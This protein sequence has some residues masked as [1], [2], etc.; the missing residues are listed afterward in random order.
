MKH[1][2][3]TKAL[4]V[5]LSF[6]MVMSACFVAFPSLADTFGLK[7]DAAIGTVTAAHRT[8]LQNALTAYSNVASNTDRAANAAVHVAEALFPAVQDLVTS[9]SSWPSAS[10]SH[11]TMPWSNW[12][13][14]E[15]QGDKTAPF[16]KE[17]RDVILGYCGNNTQKT[18]INSLMPYYGNDSSLE[19]YSS[20]NKLWNINFGDGWEVGNDNTSYSDYYQLSNQ[21]NPVGTA[22]RTEKQALYDYTLADL[23]SSSIP[24]TVRK[25]YSIEYKTGL[26]QTGAE[27]RYLTAKHYT[28]VEFYYFPSGPA[29][30]AETFSI[31]NYRDDLYTFFNR[32]TSARI[33]EDPFAVYANLTEAQAAVSANNTAWNAV[34]G[35]SRWDKNVTSDQ[36]IINYFGGQVTTIAGDTVGSTGF[37]NAVVKY[38][39][40]CV[41]AVNYYKA[42]PYAEYIADYLSGDHALDRIRL[43]NLDTSYMERNAA[44]NLWSTLTSKKNSIEDIYASTKP[45]KGYSKLG[46]V[47]GYY[48][49]DTITVLTLLE[50][51]WEYIDLKKLKETIDEKIELFTREVYRDLTTVSDEE[52]DILYSTVDGW[53]DILDSNEYSAKVKNRVF[54]EGYQ[55]VKDYLEEIEYEV[56]RRDFHSELMPIMAH[57]MPLFNSNLLSFTPAQL[58]ARINEDKAIYQGETWEPEGVDLTE[59]TYR[60]YIPLYNAYKPNTLIREDFLEL[61]DTFNEDLQAYMKSLHQALADD[62]VV[63]VTDAMNYT[64]AGTAEITLNNFSLIKTSVD[65][66]RNNYMTTY[67]VTV[68]EGDDA[69]EE[70]VYIHDWLLN[71]ASIKGQTSNDGEGHLIGN[72]YDI[73]FGNIFNVN[74]TMSNG[75]VY[76]FANAYDIIMNGDFMQ[77]YEA[78][79]ATGGLDHWNQL[80]FYRTD[81]T[82]TS[83]SAVAGANE[84]NQVKYASNTAPIINRLPYAD[85]LGRGNDTL[86]NDTYTVTKTKMNDL[87]NQLDTFLQSGDMVAILSTL[88]DS[89]MLQDVN[90]SEYVM[91]LLS[92]KLFTDE[93]MNKLTKLIFPTLT[94]KLELLWRELDGKGE[95]YASVYTL[96]GGKTIYYIADQLHIAAYPSQIKNVFSSIPQLSQVAARMNQATY[97]RGDFYRAD[98]WTSLMNED[99]DLDFVWGIDA[100]EKGANESYEAW[101]TRR[102]GAFKVAL[103][104]VLNCLKDIA[105]ALFANQTYNADDVVDVVRLKVLAIF[106]G[107]PNL[108]DFEIQGINGY[109]RVIVPLLEALGCADA[110]IIPSGQVNQRLYQQ[111]SNSTAALVNAIFDPIVHLVTDQIAT[112]PLAKILD[113]LPNLLYFLAFGTIDELVRTL[114]IKAKG[115]VAFFKISTIINVLGAFIDVPVS[116]DGDWVV[117]NILHVMGKNSV[118]ELIEQVDITDLNDIVRFVIDMAMPSMSG[119]EVP[120]VDVGS[121]LARTW[122]T[123]NASSKALDAN[124]NATTRK[125]FTADQADM[126]YDILSWVGKAFQNESFIGQLMSI[127]THTNE[128]QEGIIAD[129]LTGIRDG[130]P[131]AFVCALVELFQPKVRNSGIYINSTYKVADYVWYTSNKSAVEDMQS[132]PIS[133]YLYLNYGNDWTYVKANTFVE[134]A[135]IIITKLLENQLKEREVNSFGEWLQYWISQAWSNEALTMVMRLLVKMGGALDSDLLKYVIS[136][137]TEEG[138]DL[139]QWNRYWG[140]LYADAV[141]EEVTDDENNVTVT[142][143]IGEKDFYDWIDLYNQEQATITDLYNYITAYFAATGGMPE[144]LTIDPEDMSFTYTSGSADTNVL[145]SFSVR[146]ANSDERSP[147]EAEDGKNNRF[148]WSLNGAELAEGD[149][150]AFENMLATMLEGMMPAIDIFLSGETGKLFP[151]ANGTSLLTIYGSNGYDSAIVPLF[152]AI[153]IDKNT[154]PS[155]TGLKTQVE[156]DA[157]PTPE[158]KVDYLFDVAFGYLENIMGDI[159][160]KL[161]DEG[162]PIVDE[163]GN[164]VKDYNVFIRRVLTE[165]L[166]SIIYFIQSN[167]LSV[168]VRNL[169]QPLLT[170]IDDVRPIFN[171]N[172]FLYEMLTDTIDNMMDMGFERTASG[173]LVDINPFGIDL[174]DLSVHKIADIL[175]ALL[176][177][178]EKAFDATPLVYGI[179]AICAVNS[180]VVLSKS[181]VSTNNAGVT[182]RRLTFIDGAYAYDEATGTFANV[183]DPANIIT[184]LLSLILDLVLTGDNAQIITDLIGKIAGDNPI[185]ELIPTVVEALTNAS[186]IDNYMMDPNWFYFDGFYENE[187]DHHTYVWNLPVAEAA[188]TMPMRSIFYLRYAKQGELSESSNLWTSNM[189]HYLDQ[190]FASLVDMIIGMVT[191]YSSLQALLNGEELEDGTFKEGLWNDGAILFTDKTISDIAKLLREKVVPLVESFSE[192][193]NIFLGFDASYWNETKYPVIEAEDAQVL[194]NEDFAE[195]LGKLFIPFDG[196]EDSENGGLLSW[197]LA[198]R[199]LKLFYTYKTDHGNTYVVDSSDHAVDRIVIKGAQGYM[200]ALVPIIEALGFTVPAM[201]EGDTGV[202]ILVKAI[203]AVLNEVKGIVNGTSLAEGETLFDNVLNRLANILYF[204]NANGIVASVVNLVAPLAPLAMS[205]AP[206]LVSEEGEEGEE[207]VCDRDK[208]I[209]MVDTLIKNAFSEEVDDGEGGTTTVSKLPD[210]FSI[211]DLDLENIFELLNVVMGLDINS[212][213]TMTLPGTGEG[214]TVQYNYL[215][216]FYLGA[217]DPY[218][219]ANG[220]LSYRMHFTDEESRADMITILL[221]TVCDV[222]EGGENDAFFIDMF[223]PDMVDEHGDKIL[224]E[225]GDPI[226]DTAAGERT[227]RKILA[228]LNTT[229]QGYEGYDWFYFDHQVRQ[230]Y[231]SR[232]L[233]GEELAEAINLLASIY[234][235]TIDED[236]YYV[237]K[238]E[239]T[240]MEQLLT[241]YL[242]YTDSNIWKEDTARAVEQQFKELMK[243]VIQAVDKDGVVPDGAADPVGVYLKSLFDGL[244]LYSKANIYKVGALIGNAMGNIDENLANLIG[245]FIEGFDPH[246]WDEYIYNEPTDDAEKIGTTYVNDDGQTITYIANENY[247]DNRDAFVDGLVDIFSS[248]QMVLN[249]LMVGDMR[250]EHG[251]AK[252]AIRLFFLKDN[253]DAIVLGGANG[254]KEALVPLLEALDCEFDTAAVNDPELT[255]EEAVRLTINSLLDRIDSILNPAEGDVIDQIVGLLPNLIYFINANGLSVTVQNLL[256]SVTTLLEGVAAIQGGE[257]GDINSL[258]GL[259]KKGIDIYDLSFEGICKAVTGLTAKDDDPGLEI[260]K[261]ISRYTVST[262]PET[263]EEVINYQPSYLQQFAV[264]KVYPYES[265]ADRTYFKMTYAGEDMEKINMF[266]ILICTVIDVFKYTDNGAFLRR[267][268]GENIYN[269]IEKILNFTMGEINYEPFDWFYFSEVAKQQAENGEILANDGDTYLVK[270][271]ESTLGYLV[272]KN[273]WNYGPDGTDINAGTAG[274]IRQNFYNIVN[275]VVSKA[276][277]KDDGTYYASLDEFIADKWTALNLCSTENVNKVS[278][279]II[280]AVNG[281]D[282]TIKMILNL[283]LGIDLT[284][285]EPYE[286]EITSIEQ[287]VDVLGNLLEPAAPVLN[288]FLVGENTPLELFYDKDGGPA[289]S[290]TGANGFQTAIIPILEAFG[291]D[292]SDYDA[293]FPV[294]DAETGKRDITG[295]GAIKYTATKLL[296]LVDGIATSGHALEDVVAMIPEL[297][298]FINTNG[299]SVSI[300]NLLA[301][302]SKL[303]EAVGEFM[304]VGDFEGID[305]V[306]PILINALKDQEALADLPLDDDFSLNDLTITGIFGIAEKITGIKINAAVT[307]DGKNVY[308]TLALGIITRFASK[309]GSTA[310]RMDPGTYTYGQDP[311]GS[312][313]NIDMISI[314]VA[315]LVNV[316]NYEEK[317]DEGIVTFANI[318]QFKKLLPENICNAIHNLLNLEGDENYVDYSW[319]HTHK[320]ANDFSEIDAE[321]QN[322]VITPLNKTSKLTG[323]K[324]Y[325]RYWTR[326]M[327]EYVAAN[328]FDVVNKVLLLLGIKIGDGEISLDSIESLITSFIGGTLYS[329][330]NMAKITGL[331]CN[332][333]ASLQEQDSEGFISTVLGVA[334]GIDLDD[335]MAYKDRTDFGFADGDRNGF[336][337]VLSEFFSPLNPLLKWLLMD[338]DI[339]LFYN[340]RYEDLIVIPG[341]RGYEYAFIPL[342]EAIGG[343]NDNIKTFAEYKAHVQSNPNAV[344]IDVLNPLLDIVDGLLEDPLNG[345]LARLPALAYFINSK[346]VY[347]VVQNIIH[348]VIAIMSALSELS[349]SIPDINELIDT[350]L[351][352]LIDVGLEELDFQKL[353]ELIIGLLPGNL[354]N[355]T[356]LIVDAVGEFTMGVIEPYNSKTLGS[357][358]PLNN[359]QGHAFTMRYSLDGSSAGSGTGAESLYASPADMITTILRFLL[360]WI[361]MEENQPTIRIF[362]N[363]YVTDEIARRYVHN[364]YD[365]LCSFL[366]QPF[367]I[368]M[369]MGTLYYVFF[370][371]DVGTDGAINVVQNTGAV[372]GVLSQA[373]TKLN[374]SWLAPIVVQLN[375]TYA[376]VNGANNGDDDPGFGAGNGDGSGNGTSQTQTGDENDG[377]GSGLNLNFFQ[378]LIKWFQDLFAKIMSLF[379]RG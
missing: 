36:N 16:M 173:E 228:M 373:L 136:R 331:V 302:V 320:A 146:V 82:M 340:G 65:R 301:P 116:T 270:R 376:S 13:H 103:T 114:N 137:F 39:A 361:T 279:M 217:V 58:E 204:V 317:D 287:F 25:K 165:S 312:L 162:H 19:A 336:V 163:E 42:K 294:I 105:F 78:F 197:L 339:A 341:G 223:S 43:D 164:P 192:L 259:D 24:E 129:V 144:G 100:V 295:V 338:E 196:G 199:D 225:N 6:L 183:N 170:V 213:V 366:L 255:G 227:F 264:G 185:I 327:A 94:E 298:Y 244:N 128:R 214:D 328:L 313:T 40:A 74:V 335:I 286:G 357:K 51:Y 87:I 307:I 358:N 161:D 135:D 168:A 190:S 314:L 152:E 21:G 5:F 90:L 248:F 177:T 262:D 171:V 348:P 109:S 113:V 155:F 133:S 181:S 308:K 333:I 209:A 265:A 356:P 310:Y 206:L 311:N 41:D 334:L 98:E 115:K 85:D 233:A 140:F 107:K 72:F 296:T 354:S 189:A 191:D 70:Q 239:D 240:T 49:E 75:A 50:D 1:T 27:K 253:T 28:T 126:F 131:A 353:F 363:E 349:E 241:G 108:E 9:P 138:M 202:T 188:V 229:V 277:K 293:K 10:I 261:A 141:T 111:S 32:F 377:G 147:E 375:T 8:A 54:P 187:S 289:I 351:K 2:K 99:G 322:Q 158:E 174:K 273:Y 325:D 69:H 249:W 139:T 245:V 201:E 182:Y 342:I 52:I 299:L 150:E 91:K 76:S 34:F 11:G 66:V 145:R 221:Y 119:M 222:F 352:K 272:Y 23:T 179:D 371:A 211:A 62:L 263:G 15:T 235:Q 288:W 238:K 271:D 344:L 231:T 110:D 101:F 315:T 230:L 60:C 370:A 22:E 269:A 31:K 274:Y 267:V 104:G 172:D 3:T 134:N 57:F 80:H 127:I 291:C 362:I 324:G 372:W 346:G 44:Y 250:D 368:S 148:V 169:I 306:I 247:A 106:S 297:V 56:T 142:Y 26:Y 67:T 14:S 89:D 123:R 38:M 374:V 112:A 68:G 71:V 117:I 243:L 281:L 260:L 63:K 97:S 278:D 284:N 167:G 355:L 55:Y 83:E 319:L 316:F 326:E 360:K 292:M 268:L 20:A 130:G 283:V 369:M 237:V 132:K 194:S 73:T 149:R 81:G 30:T 95:W 160:D 200:R 350:E 266:T 280:G 159:T 48:L 318:D 18:L 236:G 330:E 198:G 257:K 219:S 300:R 176:S 29:D 303:I 17:I 93:I 343:E 321:Y 282:D 92:E 365:G 215:T 45:T 290:L 7:A 203:T 64:E 220:R 275:M 276:V 180:K 118:N 305:A 285:L 216:D 175:E 242:N 359:M 37:Y 124:N 186:L 367:G 12:E 234:L 304:D 345:Q 121:V 47:D 102:V 224:D 125:K 178:D 195:E 378:R 246:A 205:I 207:P 79:V 77:R 218:Q 86:A 254:F 323:T 84:V 120:I 226:K 208:F 252:Y 210:T 154:D 193:L 251:E 143:P 157:L 166:P 153:G 232:N 61:L 88:I 337:A 256:R 258:L 33:A 379:K 309:N 364:V 53:V 212:A 184:I 96:D 122:L 332:G 329:N 46:T 59:D 4:S 151:Q 156:F 35:T 347:T